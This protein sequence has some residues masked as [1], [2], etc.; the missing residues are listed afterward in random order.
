M[1]ARLRAQALGVA[2]VV[3]LGLLGWFAVAVYDK[4]F[5][6]TATVTLRTDRV[7]T[8][9]R[10]GADVKARGVVVGSVGAVEPTAQGVDVTLDL[11]PESLD[12]LPANVSARL[13]PKTLFGQ[14]FVD[15]VLPERE[16]GRLDAGAVIDQDRTS[17][18]IELEKALR[19]LMPLLQAVQPH[20][21]AGTLG[22]VSSSLDGRGGQLGETLTGLNAYLSKLTPAMPQIQ[23]DITALADTLAVYQDVAPDIVAALAELTTTSRTIEQQR[24][25]LADLLGTLT[26]AASDLDGF[27]RANQGSIIG[28]SASSRPTL[29]LLARHSAEFPCLFAALTELKPRADAALG[30]GTDRPG[31]HIQLTVKP[32]V[33][34]PRPA[35]PA[36]GCP[37]VGG[38]STSSGLVTELIAQA[39]GMSPAD[40]P[41]W[42]D[43]LVG[44]LYR[45]AE[46]TLR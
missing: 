31:L 30:A 36:G 38:A 40:V 4:A 32:P 17:R 8:Q 39:Q 1:S 41:T 3:L 12:S 5:T 19:D 13:L 34:G 6:D 37:A 35:P 7:G 26:T 27:L 20:K 10:P 28:L 21:L 43:L 44:P 11:R 9:L 25:G 16:T 23:D 24:T 18:A 46:V 45:G 42:G 33:P 29:E 14:R 22:A 15:L 2:F